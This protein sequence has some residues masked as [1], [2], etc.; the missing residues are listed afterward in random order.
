MFVRATTHAHVHNKHTQISPHSDN[1]S[2]L[3]P[4][5][6][7]NSI[8]SGLSLLPP[9]KVSL[10]SILFH[11]TVTVIALSV[12]RLKHLVPSLARSHCLCLLNPQWCCSLSPN[13]IGLLRLVASIHYSMII[14]RS[15][16]LNQNTRTNNDVGYS[17]EVCDNLLLG[18][19]KVS[20]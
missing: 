12:S 16:N 5:P 14:V 7:N 20:L 10:N 2:L 15:M 3:S 6:H 13:T 8:F 1:I 17:C 19:S 18:S 11:L 9:R 4:S